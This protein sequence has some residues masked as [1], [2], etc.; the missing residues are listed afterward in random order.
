M[1]ETAE[2][3]QWH[4]A[5]YAGIQ[6]EFEKEA[7]KLSFENEHNLSTKPLQVDVLIIKKHVGETIKKNIGQIKSLPEESII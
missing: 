1:E 4:P 2:K 5:F 7:E 6:I 3:I